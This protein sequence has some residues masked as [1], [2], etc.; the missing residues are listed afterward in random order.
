LDAGHIWQGKFEMDIEKF[1]KEQRSERELRRESLE[2]LIDSRM[3][4]L[5]EA[6]LF[7]A[8][9]A[10]KFTRYSTLV[11]ILVIILGALVATKET[12]SL[13]VG[14]SNTLSIAGYTFIG[15]LISVI[16]GL[17]ATFG[18]GT[19]SGKLA[20][21]AAMCRETRQRAELDRL[22]ISA[23]E[24]TDGN[25]KDL[26]KLLDS[27]ITKLQEIRNETVSSGFNPVG[28]IQSVPMS[29]DEAERRGLWK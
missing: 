21:L 18:W 13:L 14:T 28:E 5:R 16:T 9:R 15:V 2:E 10:K 11:K 23:R 20:A 6:Q 29:K 22:Q 24:I 19:K 17:E 27:L 7:L 25:L 12:I 26:E 1:P 3:Y 8:T 4:E